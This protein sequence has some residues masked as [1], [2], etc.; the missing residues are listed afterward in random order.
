MKNLLEKYL[1]PPR[2]GEGGG[3]GGGDGGGGGD[4]WTAPAGLPAELA[5]TTADETLAK[6]LPAFNEA[7]TRADGLREKLSKAPAAPKSVDEYTFEPG[8][9]LKPYFG[10]LATDPAWKAARNAAFENGIGA[11]QLSK[12]VSGVYEP[13]IEQG[14]LS[15][16]FDPGK[17]LKSFAEAGGFDREGATAA[18]TEAETFANGL[19]GQ[20]KGVP[21]T[22]K[23]DVE[24]LL[25]SMTDTAAGNYLLRGL[26]GRLAENG[27][28]IAGEGGD[29]G[30]LTA[31]DLKTLDKD[32]R[33]DPTNRGNKDKD[34][35]YDEDLRKR[36]DEAYRR[37]NP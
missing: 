28:R 34:K 13:M 33:I 11:E 21:D 3:S 29:A 6:I 7:N 31:E 22:L 35:R 15:P 19:A 36:Y 12:F 5:G 20:L 37:L 27:I 18:L 23:S 30:E 10:D 32:P 17:E 8:D 1:R 25:V 16:P 4:A 24:A 9:K 2:E 14:L 26:S